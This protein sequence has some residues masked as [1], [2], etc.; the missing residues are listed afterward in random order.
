MDGIYCQG[1]I[2]LACLGFIHE[3]DEPIYSSEYFS[4]R[5]QDLQS[6][7]MGGSQR[8][9]NTVDFKESPQFR[10]QVASAKAALFPLRFD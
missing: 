10:L 9:I 8:P 6:S 3:Q 2:L 7:T 4:V 1:G 5:L